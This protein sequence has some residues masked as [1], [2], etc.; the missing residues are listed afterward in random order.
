MTSR[1]RTKTRKIQSTVTAHNLVEV[2]FQDAAGGRKKYKAGF[3]NKKYMEGDTHINLED[4][5]PLKMTEDQ[6]NQHM[7]GVIFQQYSCK[8]GLKNL[9]QEGDK[10][11]NKE[12]QQHHDMTFFVPIDGAKLSR[13]DR[14]CPLEAL[15]FT[16]QKRDG[17]VKARRSAD[18]RGQH[19]TIGKE[20]YMFFS[21][22]DRG[23]FHHCSNGGTQG[24]AA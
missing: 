12:L 16:T 7:M 22:L 8:A 17:T 21:M 13:K 5:A 23:H 6:V 4:K 19:G 24:H 20:D 2:D 1:V 18:G 3:T 14:T 15:M 11:V 9:G 10:A